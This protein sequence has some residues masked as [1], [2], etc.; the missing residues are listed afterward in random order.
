MKTRTL[1]L[2]ATLSAL[3]VVI[4]SVGALIDTIDLTVACVTSL[5]CVFAVIELGL[6]AAVSIWLVTG[7]LA[8][9]LLPAKFTA[10]EYIVYAGIYPIL[11]YLIE[12]RIKSRSVQIAAKGGYYAAVLVLL[13]FASKLFAAEAETGA[14]LALTAVT[15]LAA[16]SIFDV[17]LTRLITLYRLKWRDRLRIDRFIKK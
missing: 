4:L 7:L 5:I 13:Y 12:S 10:V 11:K 3:G 1:A 17:L 8:F 9:I 6:R 14:L 2:C 15:A 16:F